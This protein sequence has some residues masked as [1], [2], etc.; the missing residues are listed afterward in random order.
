MSNKTR[1]D[2]TV[3][4]SVKHAKAYMIPYAWSSRAWLCQGHVPIRSYF[5]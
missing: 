3:K 5:Y 4:T 2:S 1:S